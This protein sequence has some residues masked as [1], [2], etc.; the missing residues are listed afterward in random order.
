LIREVERLGGEFVMEGRTVGLV[1]P[2]TLDSAKRRKA[3]WFDRMV[4]KKA[5]LVEAIIRDREASHRWEASG[6]DPAWWKD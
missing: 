4:R 3:R 1:W 2:A 5:Y 6:R